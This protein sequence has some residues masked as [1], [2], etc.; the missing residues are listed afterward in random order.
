MPSL[1]FDDLVAIH[2]MYRPGPID[3]FPD[4]IARK[5]GKKTV[6][7]H[8][9]CM[10]KYLKDTHGILLYQEQLMLLL[11]QIAGFSRA[12]SDTCRKALG[13]K[14]ESQIVQYKKQFI[15]G[16][17]DFG[18]PKETLELIWK[19]WCEQAMYL[20]NKSHAVCYTL[21][22][23]QMMYLKVH[24]PDDFSQIIKNRKIEE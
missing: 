17:M 12:D 5:A 4:Y 24:Y 10:E 7:F 11:Q 19:E 21:I 15:E 8:L 1:S 2:S 9:P 6:I 16:G 20:F 13:M 18:H 14:Q 3:L 22:A 23:Y